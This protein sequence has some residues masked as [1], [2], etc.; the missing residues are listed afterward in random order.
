MQVGWGKQ[1]IGPLYIH[2]IVV[3]AVCW[4]HVSDS[5]VE[6]KSRKPQSWKLMWRFGTFQKSG[7]WSLV[8]EQKDWSSTQC[9]VNWM[10]DL[11]GTQE[12]TGSRSGG[13]TDLHHMFQESALLCLLLVS[14]HSCVCTEN[15]R[16]RTVGI[17]L[18]TE[19]AAKGSFSCMEEPLMQLRDKLQ[20]LINAARQTGAG[21]VQLLS[22]DKMNV[23]CLGEKKVSHQILRLISAITPEPIQHQNP[24]PIQ[25]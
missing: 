11:S 15:L 9:W 5:V 1:Y 18:C 14:H 17:P 20:V 12:D 23:V 7:T 6:E 22:C 21:T 2:S 19:S 16:N 25:N 4:K 24:G 8:T 10:K 3:T 13:D